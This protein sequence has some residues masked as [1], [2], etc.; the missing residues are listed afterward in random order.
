MKTIVV[1]TEKNSTVALPIAQ[2]Y[3]FSKTANGYEGKMGGNHVI[4][5]WARGHLLTLASPDEI[6]PDLGWNKPNELAPLPRNVKIKP[7]VEK[8]PNGE[9]AKQRLDKIGEQLKKADE[10]ILATDA[11]REG[12]YI[13]W[14][15]LEY[16][17]FKGPVQRLW[18]AEG[19]DPISIKKSFSSL[20][21]ASSKKSLARAAEARAKCDW[22]YMYL[23]RLMTHYGQFGLL[24]DHLGRGSGRERV[25]S[26]GRVQSAALYMIYKRELE[27]ENF[28]PKKFYVISGEFLPSGVEIEGEY[29]PVVTKEIIDSAPAG[30]DW[31]PQGK[32]EDK[33]LDEPL[34]IDKSKV[35]AFKD[36]LLSAKSESKV[37]SFSEGQRKVHPGKTYDLVAA[38]S[39]VSKATGINGDAA[40]AVIEDLYEQG[41]ISY[42]RTA[43]GELPNNLY[44]ASERNPRLKA[45]MGIPSIRDGALKAQAIHDG[46]DSD[47]K[48]FKPNVFVSK[49]LEHHGLIPSNKEVSAASLKNIRARKKVNNKLLHKDSDMQVAYEIIA[50]RFVEAMLPPATVATQKVVFSV[51]VEDLLGN[52]DSLFSAKSS[53]VIDPG[54]TAFSKKSLTETSSLPILKKGAPAPIKSIDLRESETQ[55]PGRYNEDNFERAMQTAARQIDDPELRAYM[56]SGDNKP[57]GIGTPATRKDIIPTLKAR[58]YI[59][60]DKKVFF[61][62]PK[63]R[64]YIAFQEKHKQHWTYRIETTAEWEGR[65]ADL[66]ALEDDALATKMRDEFIENTLSDIDN[67]IHWMNNLFANAEKKQII[68]TASKVTDKM[69]AAIKR[70]SEQKGISVPKGTLSDPTKASAFLNEHLG[71]KSS[72]GAGGGLS[73]AQLAFLEKIEQAS[74][75][76]ASDEEKSD[77]AAA[78]RYI[79]ANKAALDKQMASN[80]PSEKMLNLA[81]N[82]AEKLPDDQK[83]DSSVF[84]TFPACKAFIDKH[85]KPKGASSKQQSG[86]SARRGK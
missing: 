6:S 79:D 74:G 19:L 63:G 11:D 46:K 30:V 59:K 36:R 52:K 54:Y 76:K 32:P 26:V 64:E 71:D 29:T 37:I 18:L 9:T 65:L 69:K 44:E 34:F 86:R 62:E 49:K 58:G 38:K 1:I 41:Y 12:E 2:T 40:Q 61:L 81:K 8:N 5:Q 33:K 50:A 82:L 60:A 24:G 85:Y 15:I 22:G 72:A 14:L 51:P 56:A 42:P 77:R 20:M 73:P 48:P 17:R 25:V 80:P 16:F 21:P 27:I 78:S 57:E 7:I 28:V 23:V 70:I 67:Y 83:P 53:R 55:K 45:V 75:V 68:P 13:G 39:E 66:A 10:V 3:G 43:H 84:E 4:I 47:Y 35:D 31:R